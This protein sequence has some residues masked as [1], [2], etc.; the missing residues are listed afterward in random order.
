[1]KK[2]IALLLAAVMCVS[3]LAACGEKAETPENETQ[4]S[5]PK[6]EDDGIMKILLI[7]SSL[8]VDSSFMFPDVCRNE[9]MENL[10]VG[11][12]YHSGSCVAQHVDYAKKNAREFAYYE[13][14]ISTQKEWLRAD[15]NGNFSPVRRGPPMIFTSRT[16][17]SPRP[18]NSAS[19][20]MTGIW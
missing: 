15:C 13:Y 14:D 8:G 2:L 5:S 19:S 12:L 16:V 6:V 3:L 11:F 18:W 4:E 10:V 1:M 17:P 20:A 9:G 7:C